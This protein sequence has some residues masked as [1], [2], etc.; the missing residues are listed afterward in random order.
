MKKQLLL[1][2]LASFFALE[3][4]NAQFTIASDNAGNYGGS[5]NTNQGTGLDA[6]SYTTGTG[7]SAGRFIGDPSS[8]GISGMSA[9]SFALYANPNV[10]DNLSKASRKFSGGAMQIG[11]IFSFQMGLN[12]DAGNNNGFKGIDLIDAF[13]NAMINFNM[14][15]SATISYGGASPL[16]GGTLFS[17][18]GTNAM[19]FTITKV[20]AAQYN[21]VAT[22]RD[23]GADFNQTL[24]FAGEISGFV[25]YA[26][27]LESGDQRQPYYNNISLSNSGVFNIADGSVTYSRNLSGTGALSKSG[28]G[29]LI[30]SS[31]NSYTGITTVSEGILEIQG[32]MSSSEIIV[33]NGAILRINGIETDI[34]ALTINAGGSVQVLS[35]KSLTINGNLTNNAGAAGLLIES[36]GSLI[37]NGTIAGTAMVKRDITGQ[38]RYH[39]ISS[40]V[41]SVTLG[42]VFPEAQYDNIYVRRYDEPTGSWVNLTT[43]DNM[44]TGIGYSFFMN[45][46]ST[47]ATF[48]GSLNNASVTPTLSYAGSGDVDYVNWNLLG[49]PFASAIDWNNGSWARS[50]IDGSVYTWDG[51]S[52]NYLSWNGFTG[53]LTGG[54]IPAQ[55]GF[56]VKVQESAPTL[57]IPKDARV[58]GTGFY[59]SGE[60]TAL[61]L[62]ISNSVNAY[63]DKTYLQSNPE[64]TAGFD[65][66]FDA[67]KL[68]GETEAPELYTMTGDTRLS[69]NAMAAPAE[70]LSIPLYLKPGVEGSFT[71]TATGLETI[72]GNAI[73]NDLTSGTLTDL[74][75]NP[76]YTFQAAPGDD[77]HRFNLLFSPVGVIETPLMNT[78]IYSYGKTIF[79]QQ[80]LAQEA[81]LSVV[82]LTGQTVFTQNLG[83][84]GLLSF[85]TRLPAGVY[86]VRIISSEGTLSSKVVIR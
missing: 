12:Y 61:E 36:G 17:N 69:I 6:W 47:T 54:I 20:G 46:A 43:T 7:G 52:G 26:G 58:H 86:I 55:Q 45:E 56:F 9:T 60:S 11:D 85:E 33:E 10:A 37:T 67:Y 22:A 28:A 51:T 65:S 79:V 25:F 84:A 24:T 13:D 53:S 83:G 14:G 29:T 1:L 57:T 73:L 41:N 49:N 3:N 31:V 48:A 81:R 74:S 27:R 5:W 8:A 39:F 21:V 62:A 82:N 76:S 23:G 35:G 30:L 63:S 2:I 72:G 4:A 32:D 34:N 70:S 38:N 77:L 68:D 66:Q 75:L 15:N 44:T 42:S 71:L 50:G 40:P 18:Y 80:Q 64:A 19:T 59:K 16:T 78:G